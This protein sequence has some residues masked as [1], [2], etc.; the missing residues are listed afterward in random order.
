MDILNNLWIGLTTENT[1]L[2]NILSIPLT[3]IEATVSLLLFTALLNIKSNKKQ[4]ITYILFCWLLGIICTFFISK[5]YSNI[6]TLIA[7]P[8]VIMYIFKIS[9]L[10]SI[11]AEFLP[12]ICITVLEIII[13]RIF[14]ILFGCSYEMCANIPIFRLISTCLIYLILFLLYILIKH[15]NFSITMFDNMI[16]K[17]RNLITANIIFAL[18]VIFMQMYLIG[19]YN[20]NLPSFIVII[21]IILLLVYAFLSI[22]SLVKTMKLEKTTQ[23]L[24]QEKLYNK[25]LQVMH[26]SV[27]AFKHDFSNIISGIGGYVETNDIDGLKSYYR[28]LLQD[29]GQVNNLGSLNPDTVN[30]PAVYAVLANKYY[31]ADSLGIKITLENFIDFNK[32]N[33]DIYEFTRIL[34]ILMDNAIEASSECDKKV[35]NVMIR[36][37]N[38]KHRQLLIIENTY[39][40]K[41]VDTVKIYEKGF[42]TKPKNTGLGLWEVHKIVTKHSN[43]DIFTTNNDEFFRQQLE[44]YD[45]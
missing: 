17:N 19:Y 7:I 24:E 18:A 33:M 21:N 27:R 41:S 28:Q 39:K 29:I 1:F 20:D 5:P 35:I 38:L 42:S 13:T 34:G 26:D 36:I 6:I 11:F 32:L 45:K 3:L 31:K 12:V 30:S 2:I 8:F 10:K 40:D 14:L 23:E 44:I 43:L 37:D 15:F 22:Y 25:T 4:N 16:K 9:F